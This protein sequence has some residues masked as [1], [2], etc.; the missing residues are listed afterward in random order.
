MGWKEKEMSEGFTRILI[1]AE[2]E[3]AQA[4]VEYSLILGLIAL[5]SI[6]ALQLIGV[7]VNNLLN[8]LAGAL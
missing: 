1:R 5:F 3:D 4:L 8:F 7:R 6:S 2:S